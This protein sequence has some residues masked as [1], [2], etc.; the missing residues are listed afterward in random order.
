MTQTN[1][2]PNES[3]EAV[4]INSELHIFFADHQSNAGMSPG[5]HARE[6]H[7]TFAMNFQ[8][9]LFKHVTKIPGI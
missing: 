7:H 1:G 8:V 2:F 5:T 3:L 6:R 9:C 4:T